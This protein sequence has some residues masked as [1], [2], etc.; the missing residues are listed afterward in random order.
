MAVT[1]KT[2]VQGQGKDQR[3]ALA[4]GERIST[5]EDRAIGLATNRVYQFR[6]RHPALYGLAAF[7]IGGGLVTIFTITTY[8]NMAFEGVNM[9]TALHEVIFGGL[10]GGIASVLLAF[11]Y[12]RTIGPTLGP[13]KSDGIIRSRK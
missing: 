7:I 9:T 10:G 11:A 2:A 1:D 13:L 6:V 8:T 5:V 4:L 3:V 12:T